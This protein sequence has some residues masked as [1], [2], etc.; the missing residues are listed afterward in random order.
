MK[1]L[2]YTFAL[3]FVTLGAMAHNL[4][5]GLYIYFEKPSAWNS[6]VLQFMIGQIGRA[7]V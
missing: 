2:I 3:L 6:T 5:A 1:R 4:S 7:H